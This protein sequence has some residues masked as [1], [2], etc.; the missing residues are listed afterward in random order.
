VSRLKKTRL[1]QSSRWKARPKRPFLGDDS[2]LGISHKLIPLA[3]LGFG[4]WAYFNSVRPVFEKTMEFE[5]ERQ[6]VGTLSKEVQSLK[7]DREIL[8]QQVERS[9][10]DAATH[11]RGIVLAYL[12]D[13][14]RELQRD[15]SEYQTI[16]P[17]EALDL[18]GYSIAYADVKLKRLGSPP[19]G[20]PESYQKEALEFFRQFVDRTIPPGA[21][22]VRWFDDLLNAYDRQKLSSSGASP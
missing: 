6:R 19:P 9:Q 10:T 15:V 7:R 22:D 13:I 3:T 18:R 5:A 1:E 11:R 8:Q 4:V 16:V 14:K 21:S 20:S 12:S 2:W 17:P